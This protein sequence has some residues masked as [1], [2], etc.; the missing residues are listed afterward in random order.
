[1]NDEKEKLVDRLQFERDSFEEILARLST[2]QMARLRI[3]DQW[4]VKDIVAHI[5]AWEIELLNWLGMAAEGDSP[6]IPRPG[7]WSG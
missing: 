5:T 4:T 6:D 3:D 2:E 7:E 1:M